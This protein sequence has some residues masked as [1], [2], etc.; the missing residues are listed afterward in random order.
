MKVNEKELYSQQYIL[1]HH[2][3]EGV[4]VG[5]IKGEGVK[6]FLY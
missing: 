3:F 1:D 5:D 2:S 6:V 4:D